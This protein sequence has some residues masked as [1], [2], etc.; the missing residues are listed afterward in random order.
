MNLGGDEPTME[1][2]EEIMWD[3]DTNGDGQINKK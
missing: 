2:I 3:L 1:D